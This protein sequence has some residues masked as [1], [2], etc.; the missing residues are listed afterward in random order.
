MQI[1]K[2]TNKKTKKIILITVVAVLLVGGGLVAWKLNQKQS[3]SQSTVAPVNTVDYGPP[4]EQ[5]QTDPSIPTTNNLGD[6]KTP[7][8]ETPQP[9]EVSITISRANQGGAAQDLNVRTVVSGATQ[10]TCTATLK[11]TG[12]TNVIQSAA[13]T[14][15]VS[16]AHCNFDIPMQ[17]FPQ[18]GTWDLTVVVNTSKGSSEVTQSVA[19]IK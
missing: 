10:G 5:D 3:S 15:E 6:S 7:Q 18:D 17:V 11:K 16:S 1:Q 9:S 2:P 12:Q 8:T 19:I 14:Y 13:L 4:K